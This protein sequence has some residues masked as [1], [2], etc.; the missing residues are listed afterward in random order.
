[1]KKQQNRKRMI[2]AAI[3]LFSTKTFSEVSMREIAKLADVSPA[4]IY[5]YFDDQQHLFIEA[6]QQESKHLL[7]AL[8]GETELQTLAIKYINYMYTHDVLYQMMAYFMLEINK[9][10]T[11]ISLFEQIGQLLQLFENTITSYNIHHPKEEAQLLFS[12]LNGL[13]ISYKNLP[14][15]TND[16]TLQ[17]IYTL[18]KR[19]ID[20]LKRV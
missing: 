18:V 4:L 19:Y 5:K 11:A 13:L 16:Q 3:H 9:P 12:T 6:M 7:Q 20:H 8:E 10:H 2:D 14:G 17:L 15:H 1:M